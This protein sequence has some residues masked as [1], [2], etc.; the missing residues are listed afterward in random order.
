MATFWCSRMLSVNGFLGVWTHVR[1]SLSVECQNQTG[2]LTKKKNEGSRWTL[3][4]GPPGPFLPPLLLPFCSPLPWPPSH[5]RVLLLCLPNLLPQVETCS[6]ERIGYR[7]LRP[8]REFKSLP[9]LPRNLASRVLSLIPGCRC[10]WPVQG[11]CGICR[12]RYESERQ[13]ARW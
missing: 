10:V 9:F 2:S 3:P 11:T 5:L 8:Q 1:R 4:L 6:Q 12:G 13:S 7:Q